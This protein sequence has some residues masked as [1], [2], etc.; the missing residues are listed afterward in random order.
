MLHMQ[1][2]PRYSRGFTVRLTGRHIFFSSNLTVGLVLRPCAIVIVQS[3]YAR[4]LSSLTVASSPDPVQK[5]GKG[6]AKI[7]QQSQ[8]AQ[9]LREGSRLVSRPVETG[10]EVSSLF[11]LNSNFRILERIYTNCQATYYS[12]LTRYACSRSVT[13]S[14]H[15]LCIV[16]SR[17]RLARLAFAMALYGRSTA[18]GQHVIKQARIMCSLPA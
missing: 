8:L 15:L 11:F 2:G 5:L 10:N 7:I 3:G 18:A 17:A 12:C 1:Q 6:L 16:V 13:R 9:E 4:L 14:V